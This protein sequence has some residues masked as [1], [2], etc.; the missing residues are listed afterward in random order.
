MEKT[1]LANLK[2]NKMCAFCKHW[3]DPTNECI[4]PKSPII[5]MWKY[6]SKAKRKCLKRGVNT[7]S[8]ATCVYYEGKV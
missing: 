2:V 7:S 3:Y 5:G 8:R 6:D 4:E 1:G